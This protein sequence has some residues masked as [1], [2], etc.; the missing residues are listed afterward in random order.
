MLGAAPHACCVP[1]G[2]G[3]S[4]LLCADTTLSDSGGRALAAG[5]NRGEYP[6]TLQDLD[7]RLFGALQSQCKCL[8]CGF[9][10]L[11][12]HARAWYWYQ[13]ALLALFIQEQLWLMIPGLPWASL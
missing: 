3:N 8:L 13:C 1:R 7:I 6:E 4:L 5:L 12:Y 9:A 10:A 2:P 11:Q